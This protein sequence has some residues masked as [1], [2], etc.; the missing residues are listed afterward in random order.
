MVIL[1]S[2]FS[3]LLF[4]QKINLINKTGVRVCNTGNAAATSVVV[5]FE[6]TSNSF[7]TIQGLTSYTYATLPFGTNMPNGGSA[8][9]TANCK[10]VYFAVSLLRSSTTWGQSLPYTVRVK[11]TGLTDVTKTST[12][13]VEQLV[14]QQRN[15]ISTVTGPTTVYV[16]HTYV[17]FF[18]GKTA[19]QGYDQISPQVYLTNVPFTITE[20]ETTYEVPANTVQNT[21]WGD[22]CGWVYTPTLPGTC[23]TSSKIGNGC[24]STVTIYVRATGSGSFIPLIYD[25]SGGSFHYNSDFA[26]PAKSI[27]ITS[28]N[29]AVDDSYSTPNTVPITFNPL[30]NDIDPPP[31]GTGTV[32]LISVQTPST[33]TVSVSGNLVTYTCQA[34]FI[35]S[36][37]FT[38]I[39]QD[40]NSIQNTATITVTCVGSPDARDDSYSTTVN[41]PISF[42]PLTNDVDPSGLSLSITSTS[43]PTKGT[44]TRSGSLVTYT[45]NANV[46]GTDTFTYTVQNTQGGTD[47]A[48][49][50]ITITNRPPVANPDS[51][52]VKVNQQTTLTPSPISNDSDPDSQTITITSIGTAA[53]GTL[54]LSGNTVT[55]NR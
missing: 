7:F 17:Y 5:S 45:P 22:G 21:M 3:I 30:T 44:V 50:T 2:F 13:Y 55:Y 25:I 34:N 33:G 49:I 20:V 36:V 29:P 19:T 10:N 14:S 16:G 43:A 38:Y 6:A 28:V 40:S 31:V 23:T 8:K 37:S 42:S 4:N 15:S 27:L 53:H 39:E 47:T 52:S 51:Y 32:T 12:L 1:L 46:I 48:T 41:V 11:S 35:G 9:I 54:T 24:T 26:T 18:S